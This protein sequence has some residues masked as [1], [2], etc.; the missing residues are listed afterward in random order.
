MSR[1][2]S[3][4]V[5]KA[6]RRLIE[7][8][9]QGNREHE[10]DKYLNILHDVAFWLGLSPD[11]VNPLNLEAE[12]PPKWIVERSELLFYWGRAHAAFLAHPVVRR[13]TPEPRA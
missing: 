3:M 12:Q 1:P 4:K 13:R 10:R 9:I 8:E 6:F 5:V 2:V 11:E 7:I